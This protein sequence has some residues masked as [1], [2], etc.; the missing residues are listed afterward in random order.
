M[1]SWWFVQSRPSLTSRR[2][3]SQCRICWH[4]INTLIKLC[5]HINMLLA[6]APKTPSTRHSTTKTTSMSTNN[7]VFRENRCLWIFS[8]STAVTLKIKSRSPKC[9]QF[10]AKSQLYIQVNLVRI[11]PLVQKILCRQ[12][13]VTEFSVF[14]LLWP[15][16]LGQG[17][18]NLI[19]S[20]LCPNYIYIQA[21][22]ERIQP[23]VHNIVCRQ[24]SVVPMETQT[25]TP[26]P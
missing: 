21:N 10:F 13:S 4:T 6:D 5:K 14:L 25:P 24:E 1:I 19:S 22:L 17:H 15:W 2:T 20:L 3:I 16:K 8:F 18:Q 26:T 23:M 12:E 9:N 7:S 11:Q